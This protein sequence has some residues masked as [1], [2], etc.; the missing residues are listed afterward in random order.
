MSAAP[1][2]SRP[3]LQSFSSIRQFQAETG[4]ET[5]RVAETVSRDVA[6][7]AHLNAFITETPERALEQ[8]AEAAR[9]ISDRQNRPLDGVPLTIKDNFCTKG[10][11]TTAGSKILSDFVPTYESFVSGR[12]QEAGAVCFGKTNLDEFGMG[13]STENSFFGPTIN[14]RGVEL[15]RDTITA[16]GSSGGAAAAVAAHLCMGALATDTGGSIRQPAS[17]CGVVGMKPTYGLCSR[18]GI[19]AYAS[20]LDQAGVIA[21]TVE[22]TAVLLDAIIAPDALDSTSVDAPIGSLETFVNG[23]AKRY[24]IGIP[25]E[26]REMAVNDDLEACWKTA[27]AVMRDAGFEIEYLDLSSLKHSLP[28]YYIIALS[29]ASSNLARYDGVRYG[30]RAE[31]FSNIADMYEQTRGDGFKWETKKRIILGTYAL[32]AGYYEAYFEKA[33]RV[34]R[35]IFNEFKSAFGNVDCLIWP[36]TPVPAFEFGSHTSDPVSMYLE[37]VFTVPINLAGLPAVSVPISITSGM[38]PMGLQVIG[39][40]FG[41]AD[42]LRVAKAI[43]DRVGQIGLTSTADAHRAIQARGA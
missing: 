3:L 24:R 16:G 42:V 23:P 2:K 40:Q 11:R 18:R 28:T 6:A 33:C 29:E 37:D 38:L 36:T 32:S 30:L 9:R 31:H 43:E 35:V 41:D 1:S 12:A 5:L 7:A 25:K 13:S 26:F 4:A 17:F 8:A 39:P 15:G 34:R 27:E 20:S 21:R 22:D 10:I 19:V 14:P